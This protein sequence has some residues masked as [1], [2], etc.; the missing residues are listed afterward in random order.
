MGSRS[1]SQESARAVVAGAVIVTGQGVR[2]QYCSGF[3]S[4]S[5]RAESETEKPMTG[6]GVLLWW[7]WP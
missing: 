7:V 4:D 3:G 1:L 2:Q 5:D 6:E